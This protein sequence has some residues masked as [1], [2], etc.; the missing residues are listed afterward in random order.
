MSPFHN[1][2]DATARQPNTAYTDRVT[3][4][5][6][7]GRSCQRPAK[8]M[9]APQIPSRNA[10][11]SANCPMSVMP[12]SGFGDGLVA[13]AALGEHVGGADDSVAAEA[14][15]DDDLDVVRV[16]EGVGDKAVVSDGIRL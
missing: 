5:A 14:A 6:S 9:T 2:S 7:S 15:F 1:A 3:V 12:I 11:H 10:A 16:G 13:G 8:A 4:A